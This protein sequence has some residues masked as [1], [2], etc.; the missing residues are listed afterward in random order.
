MVV[1]DLNLDDLTF[2]E[3]EVKS[4]DWASLEKIRQLIDANQFI[5]Y[6]N[7]LI[8]FLFELKDAHYGALDE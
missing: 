7:G 8:E 4:A 3:T 6:R 2:Q 1:V 5:P